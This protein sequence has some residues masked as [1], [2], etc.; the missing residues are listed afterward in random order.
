MGKL[1]LFSQGMSEPEFAGRTELLK[2]VLFNAGYY[3]WSAVK[4]FYASV[5]S[6]IEMGA[7]RWQDSTGKLEQQLLMPFPIKKLSEGKKVI[8]ASGGKN[9]KAGNLWFCGSY[10]RN[11][12]N[13]SDAHVS[14][15]NGKDMISHHICASCWLKDKK[16]VPH[17][18]SSTAC[19]HYEH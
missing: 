14:D 8:A 5:L 16:K 10:Q 9:G 19:P 3:E 2:D 11:E 12:C 15:V 6:E 13:Q 17:P 4:R 1:K 18:S 7:R